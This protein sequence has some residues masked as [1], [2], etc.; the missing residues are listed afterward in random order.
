MQMNSVLKSGGRASFRKQFWHAIIA[1]FLLRMG[2][3]F[4]IINI[5]EEET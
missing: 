1:P 4:F 2:S 5:L 3:S